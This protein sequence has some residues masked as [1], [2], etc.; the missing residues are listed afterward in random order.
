MSTEEVGEGGARR[1]QKESH[2]AVR[3]RI[4]SSKP[5]SVML[6]ELPEL[7]R[8]QRTRIVEQAL[9]LYQSIPE[10]NIGER[11]AL[12]ATMQN[13]YDPEVMPLMLATARDTDL[14]TRLRE[15]AMNAFAHLSNAD[16]AV[17]IWGRGNKK[18]LI[19]S[20]V[21]DILIKIEKSTEQLQSPEL[22]ASGHSL[23][24]RTGTAL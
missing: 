20:V 8:E 19:A 11:G 23:H 1:W 21:F 17:G 12:L 15:T 7:S 9:V 6:E 5:M 24:N 10:R 3:A 4:R 14:N 2:R 22:G 18:V 13:M 16:T